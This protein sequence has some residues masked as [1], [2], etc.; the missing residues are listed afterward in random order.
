MVINP[1]I[2]WLQFWQGIGH[3]TMQRRLFDIAIFAMIT[4]EDPAPLSQLSTRYLFLE[5]EYGGS[6]RAFP[7][8]A[9]IH[10]PSLLTVTSYFTQARLQGI[11]IHVWGVIISCIL[12]PTCGIKPFGGSGLPIC[13]V[14][15][16][17]KQK[18]VRTKQAL[19]EV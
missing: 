13:E 1:Y 2:L 18:R 9:A 4:T 7:K 3:D 17:L 10:R 19:S 15:K 6:D 5:S 12:Y 16:H 14:H 11:R 8:G